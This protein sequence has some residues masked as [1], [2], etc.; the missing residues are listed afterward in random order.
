M[1]WK[2]ILKELEQWKRRR[3]R[4]KNE[5]RTAGNRRE[6]FPGKAAMCV[7]QIII[8]AGKDGQAFPVFVYLHKIM[9]KSKYIS[10]ENISFRYSAG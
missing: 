4:E 5:S 7:T 2:S 10:Y 3:S 1:L 8:E 6:E 9:F